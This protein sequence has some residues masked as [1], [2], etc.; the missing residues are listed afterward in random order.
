MRLPPKHQCNVLKSGE[1][2]GELGTTPRPI[3]L[4]AD[5]D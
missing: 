5:S 2:A 3:R 1:L 4:Y